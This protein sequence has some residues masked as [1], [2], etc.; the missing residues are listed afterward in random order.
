MAGSLAVRVEGHT[1]N[2]GNAASNVR[3]SQDRAQAVI[4]Y[5]QQMSPENFPAARFMPPV[6]YGDTQPVASNKTSAGKAANRRVV[7]ALGNQ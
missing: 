7:I 4:A 5:L 3:L 1:D 2:V 6:G